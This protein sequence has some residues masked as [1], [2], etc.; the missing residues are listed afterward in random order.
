[1]PRVRLGSLEPLIVT[2]EFAE[3]IAAVPAVMPQFHLSL[4][5]GSAGVLQR[6]RRAYTKE[7]YMRSVERLRD[8]LPGCAITT[9]I[10][11]GFPGETDAEARETL[12]FVRD[13]AFA[14]IHVFPYSRR[15]G[16]AADRMEGQIPEEIKRF[17]ARELLELG[18]KLEEAFVE[19]LTGTVQ[20][21]LFERPAGGAAAEGYTGQ[22]VRVV[23][24]ARPGEI[25]SVRILR[26]EG[27]L[28]FGEVT[29]DGR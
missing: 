27:T 15:K 11:T 13:C 22:Y 4:Q 29:Q 23:A 21:V 3:R 26:S 28:A 24:G 6:M 1:V 16:T 17:R 10:L 12:D 7:Q 20:E 2:D 8:S 14:R 5:S 18:N 25:R 9:D 19:K